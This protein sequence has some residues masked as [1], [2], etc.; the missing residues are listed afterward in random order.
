MHVLPFRKSINI[1]HPIN[2]PKKKNHAIISI[3]AER[4]A[5]PPLGDTDHVRGKEKSS[6]RLGERQGDMQMAAEA[7]TGV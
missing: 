1:L 4:N 2:K 5:V 6:E 3:A 7:G